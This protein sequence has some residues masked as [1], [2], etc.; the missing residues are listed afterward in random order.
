MMFLPG[1]DQRVKWKT[2]AIYFALPP[3]T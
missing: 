2:R 3:R 1:A